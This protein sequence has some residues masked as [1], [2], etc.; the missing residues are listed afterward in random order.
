MKH[1]RY[2]L[3]SGTWMTMF[4]KDSFFKGEAANLG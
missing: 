3:L 1:F 2:G 4:R